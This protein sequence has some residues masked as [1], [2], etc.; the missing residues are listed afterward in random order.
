MSLE[1]T[2][3]NLMLTTYN[4]NSTFLSANFLR[5]QYNQYANGHTFKVLA[6]RAAGNLSMRVH[7]QSLDGVLVD[8]VTVVTHSNSTNSY[9]TGQN[10]T[11]R[12]YFGGDEDSL[13]YYYSF[14]FT[15]FLFNFL[16]IFLQKRL[17]KGALI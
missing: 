10:E 11:R 6:T 16:L 3:G 5:S 9:F 14:D 1:L 12:F 7:D 8:H 4:T 17:N 15:F 13:R 2:S